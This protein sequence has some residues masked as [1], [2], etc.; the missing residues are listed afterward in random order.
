MAIRQ[1]FATLPAGQR[2]AAHLFYVEGLT[3]GEIA[4][5]TEVP[6]G[7]AKSRLFHARLRL[8]AALEGEVT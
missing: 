1:A 3:L 6:L 7:T 8:K 4:I 2:L 5:A